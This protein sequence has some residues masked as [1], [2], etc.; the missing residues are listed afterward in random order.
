MNEPT[1][2]AVPMTRNEHDRDRDHD[3]G[4]FVS[5]AFADANPDTTTSELVASHAVTADMVEAATRIIDQLASSGPASWW[6]DP[7][8][9]ALM[10]RV[11]LA[12]RG[13]GR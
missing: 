9:V 13:G 3:S 5:D 10:L 12:A 6:A 1:R 4:R 2:E 8:N 7:A 11:A